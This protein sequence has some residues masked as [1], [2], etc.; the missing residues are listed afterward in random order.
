M[1]SHKH[2]IKFRG[3]INLVIK[4][5]NKQ[6]LIITTEENSK[7]NCNSLYSF[8]LCCARAMAGLWKMLNQMIK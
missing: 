6:K 3:N 2:S 4:L 8:V 5:Q 1:G 7:A